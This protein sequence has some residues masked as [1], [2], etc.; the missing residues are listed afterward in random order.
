MKE[1]VQAVIDHLFRVEGVDYI[2]C[3]YLD[4]NEIS[5]KFQEKLGFQFVKTEVHEQ[6]GSLITSVENIR[7][8]TLPNG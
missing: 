2:S 1:A 7:W 6:N 3:G 8:K 5:G 4:F